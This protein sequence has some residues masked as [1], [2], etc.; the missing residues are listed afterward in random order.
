MVFITGATGL[1][2]TRLVYDHVSQGIQV[3]AL[4]RASSDMD[5]FYAVLR[6]YH[7]NDDI[8]SLTERIEWVEGDL[9][10]M[11]VHDTYLDGC[12]RCY[13]AAAIVS[14]HRRDHQ[15]M[16]EVNVSG[17]AHMVNAC[18]RAEIPL[19]HIS[20]IAALGRT[21]REG[22][23]TEASVWKDSPYNSAYA[24]S[25]YRAEMEVWRGIEEGLKASIVNPSVV[26]GAGSAVRSSGALFGAVKEGMPFYTEGGTNIVDVRDVSEIAMRLMER[27]QYSERFILNSASLPYRSVLDSIADALGKRRPHIRVGSSAL[28]LLWRLN[29][30]KDMIFRTKSK[31]TE[32]TALSS[33]TTYRYSNDKVKQRLDY[34][35]IPWQD[36][37]TYAAGYYR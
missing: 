28:N 9:L 14:F 1:V 25:K 18:L 20:S 2:G 33:T 19:C 15:K 11:A 7:Q 23:F 16:Y 27:Q 13:H 29:S 12:A 21:A 17:T 24:K 22:E 10:D 30:L 35:F 8:D 4:R 26:L 34:S 37:V 6:F 31:V 32:E 5:E 36:S 3:R